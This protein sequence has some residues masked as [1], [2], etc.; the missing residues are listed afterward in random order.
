MDRNNKSYQ[1]IVLYLC[2]VWF[3]STASFTD[4]A[5]LYA[6]KKKHFCPFSQNFLY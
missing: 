4:F 5:T 3:F 1:L 2:F 6:L